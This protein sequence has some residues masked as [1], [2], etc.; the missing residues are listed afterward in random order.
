MKFPLIIGGAI[1]LLT[2][3]AGS[4][5]AQSAPAPAKVTIDNFAFAPAE[6]TVPA[7]T[8]LTWVNAQNVRHTATADNSAWDSGILASNQSFQ[9]TLDQVGDFT[10][11]C[12]IHPD[13]VGVVH[14]TAAAAQAPAVVE[15]PGAAT[16]AAPVAVVDQAPTTN[17]VPAPAPAPT[18]TP[19]RSYNGY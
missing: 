13:M 3:G 16:E 2:M 1:A 5:G 11:H 4:V 14:V 10:Y 6:L 15:D 17:S 7:G 9:F 19:T 8:T 18:A 12:D